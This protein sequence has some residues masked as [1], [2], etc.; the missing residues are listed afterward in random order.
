[1]LL[2]LALACWEAPPE[3]PPPEPELAPVEPPEPPPPPEGPAL[4]VALYVAVGGAAAP[5]AGVP[6]TAPGEAPRAVEGVAL[7][8]WP[9][10]GVEARTLSGEALRFT[11][12]APVPCPTVDDL[13]SGVGLEAPAVEGTLI[14]APAPWAEAWVE[15]SPVAAEPALRERV[16]AR[17]D[18]DPLS[19]VQVAVDADLDGDGVSERLLFS[20]APPVEPEKPGVSEVLW[21]PELTPLAGF[22]LNGRLHLEGWVPTPAGPLLVLRSEWMGGA[23]VHAFVVEGSQPRRLGEWVCGS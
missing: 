23:G 16:L 19:I 4:P 14:L 10:E 7:A 21:G 13:V 1:M 8:R 11:G 3:A 6:A 17:P 18:T 22:E 20:H 12:A 9:S 15:A 2:L 5:L